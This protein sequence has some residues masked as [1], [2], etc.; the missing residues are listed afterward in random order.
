ML[1]FIRKIWPFSAFAAREAR[2][3]EQVRAVLAQ[4]DAT[5]R[6]MSTEELAELS[7]E[8]L[9]NAAQSRVTAGMEAC[10][11]TAE[12]LS[13]LNDVGRIFYVACCYET[14]IC[15]K[16]SRDFF[17]GEGEILL[18]LLGDA[19]H[20]IGAWD[21]RAA[22]DELVQACEK[23]D[24]GIVGAARESAKKPQKD[25]TFA[26]FDRKFAQMESVRGALIAYVRA[27]LS[28]F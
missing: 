14:I 28:D 9:Y 12:R 18:P 16:G 10:A 26:Q 6:G 3:M 17:A 11:D 1:S 27:N 22:L 7:D 23:S 4:Q 13:I 24:G 15:A 21:Q 2:M 8:E 25:D 5:W 19:L 20:R